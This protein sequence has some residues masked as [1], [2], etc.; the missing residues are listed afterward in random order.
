MLLRTFAHWLLWLIAGGLFLFGLLFG[1]ALG[2]F[3]IEPQNALRDLAE[4]AV[5]VAFSN[6]ELLIGAGKALGAL[7]T[8]LTG[9]FGLHKAWHYAERQL[10]KRLEQYIDHVQNLEIVGERN[11]LFNDLK[12]EGLAFEAARVSSR[13]QEV[14]AKLSVLTPAL[15]SWRKQQATID[16]IEGQHKVLRADRA[17][18]EGRESEANAFRCE[19]VR[20]FEKAAEADADDLRAWECAAEQAEKS[21]AYVDAIN[22]WEKLAL[23]QARLGA[24]MQQA[25]ATFRLGRVLL[26]KSRDVSVS[27]TES[28]QAR[29]SSRDCLDDARRLLT[30]Y[31]GPEPAK[32]ELLAN[33]CEVLGDV[34]MDLETYKAAQNRLSE[35]LQ[36][37]AKIEN[38]AGVGRVMTLF[39]RLKQEDPNADCPPPRN[40]MTAANKTVEG[41]GE[42]YEKLAH[43]L[44]N[45]T[46]DP[47]ARP[48]AIK[49]LYAAMAYYSGETPIPEV[50]IARVRTHITELSKAP[51][52]NAAFAK[53]EG[54]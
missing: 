35:A 50:A 41:L 46:D 27:R 48:K 10:P 44:I 36:L 23:G 18:Q 38:A 51:Q 25:R 7:I 34:R 15:D 54:G 2:L 52:P 21:L 5:H 40:Y 22:A 53:H 13:R 33:C 12:I 19:A 45:S 4:P 39:E 8:I 28:N 37:Y 20:H 31:A 30:G 49:A 47:L 29:G 26:V 42:I 16:F 17:A 9:L 14:E 11:S 43:A 6:S 3:G 24:T 1:T 32:S